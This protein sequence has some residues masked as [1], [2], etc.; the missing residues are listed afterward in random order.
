MD[1]EFEVFISYNWDIKP[2]VE[3]FHKKLDNLSI[4]AWR[5]DKDMKTTNSPLVEQLAKA[6]KKSKA[7]LCCFTKKYS[8][9]RN[10]NSEINF[11]YE[12]GKPL[13][14]L[15]I[16]K[17]DI[18]NLGG[19]GLI[20]TGAVRINCYKHRETWFNDDFESIRKSIKDNLDVC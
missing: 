17:P 3:A 2:Q 11:A 18:K 1:S 19:I 12:I 8:E 13:I 5:D 7:F 4:R 9:S 20:M 16:D 14:I 6:I 15:A 10:C